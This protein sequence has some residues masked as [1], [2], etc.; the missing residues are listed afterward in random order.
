[1]VL[2]IEN[3]SEKGNGLELYNLQNTDNEWAWVKTN[4]LLPQEEAWHWLTRK[5]VQKNSGL[6]GE[7]GKKVIARKVSLFFH[8]D[9]PFHF[10][11]EL[12][13][14]SYKW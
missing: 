14:F 5:M 9:E 12:S 8:P 13:G 10:S 6:L 2:R 3:V 11:P 7:N 1:M 4:H